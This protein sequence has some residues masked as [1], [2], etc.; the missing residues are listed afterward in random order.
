MGASIEEP[1]EV[2]GVEAKLDGPE[3]DP[4]RTEL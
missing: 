4:I 2:T 3:V 1:G